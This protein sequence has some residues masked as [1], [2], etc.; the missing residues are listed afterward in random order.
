MNTETTDKLKLWI[1]S[2]GVLIT[3]RTGARWAINHELVTEEI[4]TGQPDTTQVAY[5]RVGPNRDAHRIGGSIFEVALDTTHPL[6]FGYGD[7]A[8][9]FRNHELFLQPSKTPGATVARYTSSPL[10]SGYI[11][12]RRLAELKGTSALI[13]RR[14]GNGSVVL[15][16]DNPNFRA[17]WYGS[18]GLFLNAIFFGKA[19]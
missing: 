6:A 3:W 8:P 10:L 11:S 9:V 4:E 13:A 18:N 5:E 14:S 16:A 12:S 1:S 7:M 17:F 2:G 19:F 15:F